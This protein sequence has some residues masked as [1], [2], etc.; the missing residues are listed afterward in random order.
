MKTK[1]KKPNRPDAISG[2]QNSNDATAKNDPNYNVKKRWSEFL[3]DDGW[4]PVA[5][6][7]LENHARLKPCN[8]THGEAMFV[9]HL[10]SFKWGEDAP[11]PAYKTIARRMG[12]STKTARRLAQSLEQKKYLFREMREATTNKFHLSN[13]IK[14][15]E[16]HKRKNPKPKR[17]AE[18]VK[19]VGF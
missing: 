2:K 5:N 17:G 11:F 14:A 19:D 6:Y 1:I 8:I 10:M 13:L 4:V 15:L 16:D 7:F 9:I 18:E 12:V 3:S